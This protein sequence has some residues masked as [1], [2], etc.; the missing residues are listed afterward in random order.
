MH[1]LRRRLTEAERVAHEWPAAREAL[2][3]PAPTIPSGAM[4]ISAACARCGW[5]LTTYK[6]GDGHNRTVGHAPTC[7]NLTEHPHWSVT[8]AGVEPAPAHSGCG[9]PIAQ[10][11]H[12]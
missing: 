12:G 6:H 11:G 1:P 7:P 5:M 10:A 9:C 2:G 4:S 3:L 8:P